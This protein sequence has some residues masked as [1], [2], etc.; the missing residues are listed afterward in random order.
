[1][2]RG[3]PAYQVQSITTVV[4]GSGFQVREFSVAPGEEVPW[5]YHTEVTDWCY[6]L[7]GVVAAQTRG[8]TATGKTTLRRLQPGQSCRIEAGTVHRLTSGGDSVCRYLLVQAGGKYDFN[9][10]EA[11]G[12]TRAVAE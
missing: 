3:K 10:V 11:T 9:K 12:S 8:R 4:A 2:P 7:E 1:V 6:C 5:H